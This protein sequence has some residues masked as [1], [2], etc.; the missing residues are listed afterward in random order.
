MSNDTALS[1]R[2]HAIDP[3]RLDVIRARGTDGHGNDFV[4]YSAAGGEPLRCC[5]HAA[6]AGEQIAL[7]SFAPFDHVS[8]WTEVGPIYVHAHRCEGHDPAAGLPAELVSGARVLRTYRAN[9]TMN[10]EHNT[11]F[12]EGQDI[13]TAL[14]DLL[15][16]PDVATVHVRTVLPQCFLFSVTG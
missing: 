3:A 8:P 6:R 5:L 13:E 7:I 4:P 11:L 12:P 2:T 15:S 14:A 10:Y 1:V 9:D 16:L